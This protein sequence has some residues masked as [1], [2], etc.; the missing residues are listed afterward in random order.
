MRIADFAVL[1]DWL[2]IRARSSSISSALAG[3]PAAGTQRSDPDPTGRWA[4]DGWRTMTSAA[5]GS[6]PLAP[7]A[8]HNRASVRTRR[9]D[10]A[11]NRTGGWGSL[12]SASLG[13]MA[14]SG[15]P[16]WKHSGWVRTCSTSGAERRPPPRRR[17]AAIWVVEPAGGRAPPTGNSWSC[18]GSQ[19]ADRD[20]R[21]TGQAFVAGRPARQPRS[22]P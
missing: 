10:S 15:W 17:G 14:A 4:C 3:T 19:R 22:N 5:A 21:L 12:Y 11:G 8:G 13:R 18:A 16:P 7:P 9:V 2:R 1:A 6:I 20:Q